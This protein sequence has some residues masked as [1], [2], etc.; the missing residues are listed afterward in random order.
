[1]L[2]PGAL[3]AWSLWSPSPA[4]RADRHPE[5][6]RAAA[7]SGDVG[8]QSRSGVLTRAIHDTFPLISFGA[9]RDEAET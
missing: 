6:Y 9:P 8:G 4:I 7:S 5:W 2:S 3:R 1:M